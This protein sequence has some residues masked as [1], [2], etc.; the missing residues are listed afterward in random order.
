MKY[1]LVTTLCLPLC[2]HLLLYLHEIFFRP[3]SCVFDGAHSLLFATGLRFNMAPCAFVIFK[4]KM[5]LDIICLQSRAAIH[6]AV[7]CYLPLDWI[8]DIFKDHLPFSAIC[9]WI[10]LQIFSKTICFCLHRRLELEAVS[11]PCGASDHL[12]RDKLARNIRS[13]SFSNSICKTHF[14]LWKVGFYWSWLW[15][16]SH[17]CDSITTLIT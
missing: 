17:Y 7:F 2:A 9:H 8:T 10:E 16:H 3:L 11:E 5:E 12:K 4:K 6:W 1:P 15:P 13:L 14:S